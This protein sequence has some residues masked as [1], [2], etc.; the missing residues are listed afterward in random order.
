[1]NN[2]FFQFMEV[3]NIPISDK[4]ALPSFVSWGA[5][6]AWEPEIS[7]CSVVYA[8]PLVLCIYENY[9][10]PLY[11]CVYLLNCSDAS[12]VMCM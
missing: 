7:L 4:A 5:L 2:I 3:T 1:M 8:V 9:T 10:L 6:R 11:A 12:V